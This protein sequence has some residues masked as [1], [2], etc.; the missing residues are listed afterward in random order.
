[1]FF[2]GNVSKWSFNCFTS[3]IQICTYI[4]IFYQDFF[5]YPKKMYWWIPSKL[6]HLENELRA[7]LYK[8]HGFNF[9]NVVDSWIFLMKV[10]FYDGIHIIW[11]SAVV[12]PATCLSFRTFGAPWATLSSREYYASLPF[13]LM[14]GTNVILIYDL[15][16]QTFSSNSVPLFSLLS[17]KHTFL[18]LT[19]KV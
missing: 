10:H 17:L 14:A 12:G 16:H 5:F 13:F 11:N 19:F 2:L 15:D 4:S 3:N 7:S 1:M 6:F 8:N 18:Q 9:V